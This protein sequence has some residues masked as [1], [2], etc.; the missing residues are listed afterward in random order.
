MHRGTSSRS[1]GSAR[2]PRE[3]EREKARK[4]DALVR[5]RCVRGAVA[6]G[7]ELEEDRNQEADHVFVSP[8]SIPKQCREQLHI[9]RGSETVGQD[10]FE[11]CTLELRSLT[12]QLSGLVGEKR[13]RAS[14]RPDVRSPAPRSGIPRDGN[15]STQGQGPLNI[16]RIRQVWQPRL[17]GGPFCHGHAISLK[18]RQRV[19]RP[20]SLWTG[21]GLLD[22]AEFKA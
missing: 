4:R 12:D 15:S 13:V 9:V 10:S 18:T 7:L 14:R 1:L 2:R 20:Q 11:R 21:L 6:S 17:H 16:V 19:V 5:E 22:K 3:E 8:L